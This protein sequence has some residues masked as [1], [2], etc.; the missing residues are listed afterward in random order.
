MV[1]Q[2]R[3]GTEK[4]QIPGNVCLF[5]ANYKR[6]IQDSYTLPRVEEILDCL[7]GSTYF[8]LLD[9]KSGYHQIEIEE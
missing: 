9:L 2:S 3:T 5:S 8:T 1:I 7:A 4:R 6:T